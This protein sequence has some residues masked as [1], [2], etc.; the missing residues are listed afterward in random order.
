[1][2]DRLKILMSKKYVFAL[3]LAGVIVF[4][5][6]TALAWTTPKQ[7]VVKEI[8][9]TEKRE[10]LLTHEAHLIN[11]TIYGE[12][13][14][15]DYY[16]SS[17]VKKINL[18][19][20]YDSTELEGKYKIVGIVEYKTK[21]KSGEVVL[22]RDE[23]LKRVG[24]F[25][26]G[27]FEESYT[28]NV[29]N[30]NEKISSISKELGVKRLETSVTFNI[31]VEN[32]KR[33]NHTVKMVEDPTGLIYFENVR[34]V[35]K[36]PIYRDKIVKNSLKIFGYQIDTNTARLVFSVPLLILLPFTVYSTAL[37]VRNRKPKLKGVDRYVVNCDKLRMNADKIVI[38]ESKDDL[39]K[40][41]EMTDKPIIKRRNCEFDEYIILDESTAYIYRNKVK[42]Q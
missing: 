1:M 40:V 8:V 17:L 9:R 23:F 30:L 28:L 21:V 39:K 42:S 29:S 14:V 24:R 34:N 31:F 16:P 2:K 41:L 18:T 4:G 27:K 7:V 15:S 5:A 32:G 11:N 12:Y 33:F 37:Q 22:W 13:L 38:L 36:V 25:S 20:H 6:L 10:G 26:N 35:D 19:Y 3:T